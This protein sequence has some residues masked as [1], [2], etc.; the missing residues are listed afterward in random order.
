MT[1]AHLQL[2]RTHMIRALV[3]VFVGLLSFPALGLAASPA[4][5][6]HVPSV[7]WNQ[8]APHSADGTACVPASSAVASRGIAV[9]PDQN[10]V[11]LGDKAGFSTTLVVA[12]Y[13][14]NSGER[15]W[16]TSFLVRATGPG[17][18][19]FTVAFA[20]AG[21][22]AVDSN[23]TI[24][25]AGH[26]VSTP[27]PVP[28]PPVPGP[29]PPAP[30]LRYFVTTC[31]PSGVCAPV[32]TLINPSI[33]ATHT[34]T[35]GGIAVGPDGHPVLTGLA[36][37]PGANPSKPST[38]KLLTVKISRSS[39]APLGFAQGDSNAPRTGSRAA[40]TVDAS[41]NI[42]VTG[43][44]ASTWKYD[45]MLSRTLWTA[46]IP[47][48]G[49]AMTTR[50]GHG[51]S[52][53]GQDSEDAVAVVGPPVGA[54]GSRH[55]AITVLDGGTGDTVW[56]APYNSGFDD[57][58]RGVAADQ[59]GNLIVATDVGGSLGTPAVVFQRGV[60][61]SVDRRGRLNWVVVFPSDIADR[62]LHSI[63]GIAVGPD[64]A[65]VVSDDSS[66]PSAP[67]AGVAHHI[68]QLDFD[69]HGRGRDG[70]DDDE[71]DDVDVRRDALAWDQ[72]VTDTVTGFLVCVDAQPVASCQD[73]GKPAARVIPS[74]N[75]GAVT[76]QFELA[77]I[78]ALTKGRH[79]LA[80][81]AYNGAL[82][83][84]ESAGLMVEVHGHGRDDD[85][86]HDDD[87]GRDDDHD[88]GRN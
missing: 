71:D 51:S 79:T 59:D 75:V 45:A 21:G 24:F 47:G 60:L 36:T 56:T 38:Y 42:L 4:P 87:H 44:D 6:A 20:Q 74:T 41:S 55:F 17:G 28:G 11:Y 49:I 22:V 29:P 1:A 69:R 25:I 64:G 70:R 30:V 40:V 50:A 73:I 26:G 43:S 85:H 84:G 58:P 16:C 33:T 76:Y 54:T 39:L 83:G 14:R 10:P 78:T 52:E 19:P 2:C 46:R 77:G 88:H 86:G 81:V 61:V 5:D 9:G 68:I 34:D 37:F 8:P 62:S 7:L 12:K 35:I 53:H 31:S 63:A 27:F 18:I 57:V 65:P 3:L 72:P 15:L 13:D 23:G 66:D 48:N 32:V 80:V 67:S 82:T